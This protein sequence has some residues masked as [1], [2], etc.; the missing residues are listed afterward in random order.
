MREV[1]VFHTLDRQGKLCYLMAIW[2]GFG[3]F[4]SIFC[5]SV[6]VAGMWLPVP[7]SGLQVQREQLKT[8]TSILLVL[9]LKVPS[10]MMK[11]I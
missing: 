7:R 9:P 6:S 11:T 4:L 2:T 10:A 1:V 3:D 5:D 8:M